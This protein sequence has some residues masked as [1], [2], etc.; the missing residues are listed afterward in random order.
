MGWVEN[1]P[2]TNPSELPDGEMSEDDACQ[3]HA[4]E[5]EFG[6]G[7]PFEELNS[8][9]AYSAAFNWSVQVDDVL[10]M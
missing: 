2:E 8:I 7:D 4:T 10:Q 5:G 1:I 3:Q 9:E 6:D